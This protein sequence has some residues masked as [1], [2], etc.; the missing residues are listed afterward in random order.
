MKKI[1]VVLKDLKC[2][3]TLML[4]SRTLASL[5]FEFLVKTDI[6]KKSI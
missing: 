4:F 6:T 3:H 5:D 2:C 1:V